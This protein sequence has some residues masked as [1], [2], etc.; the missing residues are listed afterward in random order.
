MSRTSLNL[1]QSETQK[2][3][4]SLVKM[5]SLSV[6]KHSATKPVIATG[7]FLLILTFLPYVFTLPYYINMIL[8][9]SPCIVSR[10]MAFIMRN[11]RRPHR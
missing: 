1:I 7:F 2:N 9:V 8:Q 10:E 5:A 3:S 4:R 11:P 6:E